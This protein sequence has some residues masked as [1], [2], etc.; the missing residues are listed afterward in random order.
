MLASAFL[1]LLNGAF[2]SLRLG[3]GSGSFPRPLPAKEERRCVERW[4][5][6]DLEAR[7]PLCLLSPSDAAD[8]SRGEDVGAPLTMHINNTVTIPEL[9][10]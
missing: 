5:Q 4:M 1:L 2:L 3:A 6:G 10:R 7:H 9:Y 8:E